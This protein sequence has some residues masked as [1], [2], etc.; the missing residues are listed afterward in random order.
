VLNHA[1]HLMRLF[2]SKD[3]VTCAITRRAK[4][5]FGNLL[6]ILVCLA[7]PAHAQK[8]LQ[9]TENKSDQI[10][11]SDIRVD[12]ATHAIGIQI[13]LASYP[14]RAGATEGDFCS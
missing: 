11:R 10:L 14:D 5:W 3:F 13:P 4:S 7:I 2:I 6:L 1:K 8:E 12:P 9:Q